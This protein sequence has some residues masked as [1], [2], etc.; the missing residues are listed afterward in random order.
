MDKICLNCNSFFQDI[1]ES[2]YILEYAAFAPFVDE[3]TENAGF[4]C[5]REL[6]Q[7]KRLDGAR[8]VC[9]KYEELELIEMTSAQFHRLS[10][11]RRCEQRVYR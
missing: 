8:E 4:S 11:F 10:A 7:K 1:K 9:E 6:Y 2:V 3:I 5:C